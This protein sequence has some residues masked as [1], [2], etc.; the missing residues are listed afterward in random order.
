MIDE[1]KMNE[2]LKK[3]RDMEKDLDNK[4]A[5]RRQ[6][7]LENLNDT[8][9]KRRQA[10]LLKLQQE[11]EQERADVSFYHAYQLALCLFFRSHL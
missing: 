2:L 8:L 4:M 10:K 6:K 9:A 11:Q 3:Q 7:Q 1:E 5:L